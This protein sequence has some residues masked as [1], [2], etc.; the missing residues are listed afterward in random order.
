[1]RW[2]TNSSAARITIVPLYLRSEEER[3]RF[4]SHYEQLILRGA[5]LD[6]S[7]ALAE[8]VWRVAATVPKSFALFGDVAPTLAKLKELGLATGVPFK[9][10]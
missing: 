9:L 3:D 4:F 5:G 7:A 10:E 2:P 6:V 8:S 1:M